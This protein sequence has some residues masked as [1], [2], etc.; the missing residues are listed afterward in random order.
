VKRRLL[1]ST[2]AA[3]VAAGC[4]LPADDEP[5]AIAP[6]DVPPD[7][8]DPNPGSS[9]TLPESPGT[10]TVVVYL[11]EETAGG[12]RLAEAEREV[13]R[14]GIPDD[15]L[16]A[17]FAVDETEAGLS[18]A[19]PADTVL[20][21]VATD[22]EADEVVINVSGD[23]LTIQGDRLA[24]AFAQIVWTATEPSAGGYNFVRFLV[25]GASRTV[26][27]GEGVEQEGAVD[28]ADYSNLSPPDP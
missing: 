21:G 13:R 8:L 2:V 16:A 10:T 22:E 9:T 20:R 24:Q 17:L 4:G 11:L 1:A 27:D 15:R 19:I 12:V 14:G 23:L 6:D 18:T 3:L 5:Q 26:I 7:L 28:R 25:D